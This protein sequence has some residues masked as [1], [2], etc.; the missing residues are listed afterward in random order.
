MPTRHIRV[1]LVSLP[2]PVCDA[3]CASLADI[4]N[5]KLISIASGAL[6]A[7]QLLA[8]VEPDLVL[9]DATLPEDETYALVQWVA[10]NCQATRIF[11]ATL[12]SMQIQQAMALGAQVAVQR[13]DLPQ[14]LRTLVADMLEAADSTPDE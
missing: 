1:C 2:G 8:L 13:N 14:R 3:T 6:S 11:V 7:T 9:L 5:L 4:A 10:Q 12:T